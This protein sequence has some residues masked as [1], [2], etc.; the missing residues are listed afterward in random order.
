MAKKINLVGAKP[1][2][3]EIVNPPR[4]RLGPAEIAEGLAPS[5][6]ASPFLGTST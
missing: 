5:R 2:R 3:I 4:P 6:A 1:K